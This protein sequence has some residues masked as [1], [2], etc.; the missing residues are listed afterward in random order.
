[1]VGEALISVKTTSG[2]KSVLGRMWR[3]GVRDEAE[4]RLLLYGA[5][6]LKIQ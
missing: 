1:M 5:Q 6:R 3:N 2:T 4:P